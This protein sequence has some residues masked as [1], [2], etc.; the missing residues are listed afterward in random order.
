MTEYNTY[1]DE[2]VAQ[3]EFI[4]DVELHTDEVPPTRPTP[5]ESRV[6]KFFTPKAKPNAR[7]GRASTELIWSGTYSILSKLT[8][9][10]PGTEAN[11]VPLLPVAK[12]MEFQA[13]AVGILIDDSIQNTLADRFIQPLARAGKSGETAWSI[14]GPPVIVA[15]MMQSPEL[16][17]V[18]YP[19]LRESLKSYMVL[20]GPAIKKREEKE[21]KLMEQ[22]GENYEGDLDKLIEYLFAP[23]PNMGTAY[24]Q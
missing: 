21:K 18:L 6:K 14:V 15:A 9:M 23:P 17:P 19:Y 20:A 5:K 2:E 11:P 12:V 24:G 1:G 3:G 22:M 16:R 4:E 13:P 7:K 8:A 10:V